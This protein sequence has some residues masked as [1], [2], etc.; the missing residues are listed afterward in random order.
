MHDITRI[1][2][3]TPLE[4]YCCIPENSTQVVSIIDSLVGAH[5]EEIDVETQTL[6]KPKK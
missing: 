3:H 2:G 6:F 4:L 1:H 5:L